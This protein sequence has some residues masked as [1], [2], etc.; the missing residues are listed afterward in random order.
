MVQGSEDAIISLDLRHIVV[1][2]ND[3][4]E[5]MFQHARHEALGLPVGQLLPIDQREEFNALL[6]RAHLKESVTPLLARHVRKDGM[7]IDLSIM[8]S[9]I[10][11]PNGRVSGASVIARDVSDRVAAENELNA[12]LGRLQQTNE[13]LRQFA[14]VA[15]HDLREPLRTVRSFCQLLQEKYDGQ[16]DEE[17]DSW[18]RFMS[19]ATVRMQQLIDDLLEYSRLESNAQ[20]PSATDFQQAVNDAVMNLSVAIGEANATVECG[21]LPTLQA[22]H[23]QVIQLFQNLIEN[24]LKYRRD[25][26]PPRVNVS[27]T[28]KDE[29]WQFSVVDNGI[30][31]QPEFHEKVFEMFRR[32]H[33]PGRFDGTGIG[34]S[35]CRKIVNRHGGKIWI[36]SPPDGGTIVHFTMPVGGTTS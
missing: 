35:F 3:S 28:E 15:S 22:E 10:V 24:A 4:A 21:T 26:N 13:E 18:I 7:T 20:P 14:Y 32:L 34:L 29:W 25:D 1:T 30:G 2:W 17:A 27:A 36:E 23:S 5:R 16:I 33:A 12:L 31:I 9:P 11:D 19:D 8:I 6:Q